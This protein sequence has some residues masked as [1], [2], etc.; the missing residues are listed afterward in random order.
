MPLP[1]PGTERKPS[2]ILEQGSFDLVLMDLQMP[3]VHGFEA[4]AVIREKEKGSGRQL[5]IIAMTAHAMEGDKKCCLSI[6]MHGY[7]TEP[8]RREEPTA[9]LKRY[10]PDDS[11][12]TVVQGRSEEKV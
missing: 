3:K 5:P 12:Q 2:P 1:L 11:R 6:G 4:T 8:T 9:M 7:P 10:W